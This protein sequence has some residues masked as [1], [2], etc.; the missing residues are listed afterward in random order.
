MKSLFAFLVTVS[1]IAPV[2]SRAAYTITA[3]SIYKHIA[4]LASDSLEGREVGEP[5]EW[6]AAAY[7]QEVFKQIGL[8]PKGN[9]DQYLQP[10]PFNKRIDFGPGNKLT[11]NGKEL[12]IREEFLPMYQSAS[13]NFEFKE[14]IPVGFGITTEDTAYDDYKGLAVEGKAVLVMRDAPKA[15]VNPHVDFTKYSSPLFC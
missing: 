2:N 9:A 5:G 15:E 6:K 1:M 7:I 10:F 11:V 13:Q 3:D 8:E 12:L 4:I 14:V